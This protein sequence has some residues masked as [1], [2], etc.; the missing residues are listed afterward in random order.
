MRG[1]LS[2]G[3]KALG[4]VGDRARPHRVLQVARSRTVTLVAGLA[5]QK[6]QQDWEPTRMAGA[7]EQTPGAQQT[8]C[9]VQA[10]HTED[11]PPASHRRE[12]QVPGR[13]WR[14]SR[15][16][17][18]CLGLECATPVPTPG[19][20]AT[21][22]FPALSSRGLSARPPSA[23]ASVTLAVGSCSGAGCRVLVGSHRPERDTCEA[24]TTAVSQLTRPGRTRGPSTQAAT[25][26]HGR[27]RPMQPENPLPG[28]PRTRDPRSGHP[29]AAP[30]R[31]PRRVS[32]H[33]LV[34]DALSWRCRGSASP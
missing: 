16:F 1:S 18:V 31:R 2:E 17:Y 5:F 20:S 25:G 29:A 7:W 22:A 11:M 32:C 4:N 23:T 8:H 21:P 33:D 27:T 13:T 24:S 6:G 9:P 19:P 3:A 34:S 14:C 10:W 30:G 26:L 12:L 15:A 28:R